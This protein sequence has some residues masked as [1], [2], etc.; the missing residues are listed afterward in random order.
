MTGWPPKAN[1][2]VVDDDRPSLLAIEALLRAGDRHVIPVASGI[3]ALRLVRA[4]DFA[5]IL[6]DIRMPAMDGFDTAAFIR[7]LPRSRRT[8]IIFLTAAHD[9]TQSVSHG[10]EVG[11]VDYIVKPVHPEIL[12]S[13]VEVF[14]E[15]Y[16]KS[17]EL[18][19]QVAHRRAAEGKLSRLNVELEGNVRERT[20]SLTAANEA[21][22]MEVE[23][24]RRAEAALERAREAA[25]AADRAKSEFLARM[26]REVRTPMNA[27]IGMTE[28]ALQTMPASE[29]R[30]FLELIKASGESLVSV[31][32]EVLDAGAAEAALPERAEILAR[33]LA[34]PD[35][36]PDRV[37]DGGQP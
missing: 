15:L 17:A 5:V 3:E 20:A 9:D 2:L 1:I 27:I 12:N 18:A 13:K 25:E 21:L 10:Y 36:R 8:P 4:A 14:V 34:R 28:A 22:N 29:Q 33:G 7:R 35:R 24:R 26:S 19:R 11:A 6:L 16:R 32:N 23:M 37:R 31:I 30:S